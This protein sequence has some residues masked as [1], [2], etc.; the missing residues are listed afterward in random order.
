MEVKLLGERAPLNALSQGME[1]KAWG[2][3]SVLYGFEYSSSFFV[4]CWFNCMFNGSFVLSAILTGY[5]NSQ[6]PRQQ[7]V[8]MLTGK[9]VPRQPCLRAG[10]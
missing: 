8:Q 3:Q 5:E 4:L 10:A 6:N 1:A 2:F 7:L 9:E